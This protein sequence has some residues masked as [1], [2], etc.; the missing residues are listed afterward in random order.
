MAKQGA[1]GSGG[2]PSS[3]GRSEGRRQ[4][5][6]KRPAL[7]RSRQ[8]GGPPAGAARATSGTFLTGHRTR[9]A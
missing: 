9:R 8:R 5:A 6:P 3:E 7:A 1:S 4:S 2:R